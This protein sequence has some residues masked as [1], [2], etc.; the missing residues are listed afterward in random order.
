MTKLKGIITVF[1]G[2]GGGPET[3]SGALQSC[4]HEGHPGCG[5]V[6]PCME[7]TLCGMLM[8][9]LKRLCFLLTRC[10]VGSVVA[11]LILPENPG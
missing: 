4:S 6:R 8:I 2:E 5:R 7:T 10:P 3:N 9:T 1:S 11:E